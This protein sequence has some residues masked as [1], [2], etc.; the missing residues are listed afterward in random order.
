MWGDTWVTGR[1]VAETKLL[2]V[3]SDARGAG[4][5]SALRDAV[6]SALGE[7]GIGD[8]VIGAIAP[9]EAAIR[10]YE[11]RGFRRAWLQMTCF[12]RRQP[13]V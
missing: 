6:D 12:E 9:D 7:A 4:V 8:Q 10:L 2:V 11:R 3:A 1:D 5:G 13:G